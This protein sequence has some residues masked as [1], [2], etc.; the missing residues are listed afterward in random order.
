MVGLD[1]HRLEPRRGGTFNTVP[2]LALLMAWYALLWGMVDERLR[3][4]SL[5]LQRIVKLLRLAQALIVIG[6]LVVLASAVVGLLWPRWF[7]IAYAVAVVFL[8]VPLALCLVLVSAP[9]QAKSVIR[10]IERGYPSNA[11][12]LAIRVAARK[13]RDESIET[14]ELLVETAINE[15]KKIL[16]R[17]KEAPEAA[18]ATPVSGDP[19]ATPPF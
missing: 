11:R 13:L 10:L 14:E 17:M 15:G 2:P 6:I 7:P 5:K 4:L 16:R 9:L 3:G 19:A 1:P 18:P 12:E 8:I